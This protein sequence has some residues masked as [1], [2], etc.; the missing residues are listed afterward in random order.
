[1][2]VQILDFSKSQIIPIHIG[3]A[4]IQTLN[5]KLIHVNNL[6]EYAVKMLELEN[7]VNN[8]SDHSLFPCLRQWNGSNRKLITAP[9][10]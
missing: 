5:F 9:E 7:I 1:M 8:N 10:N 2:Y 3:Q 4:R 6:D